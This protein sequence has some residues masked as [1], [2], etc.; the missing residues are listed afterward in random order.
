MAA[1]DSY[2]AR[3]DVTAINAFVQGYR[4]AEMARSEIQ[5]RALAAGAITYGLL[6][7]YEKHRNTR[8]R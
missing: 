1:R 5:R 8:R 3:D 7:M 2:D 6:T 4:N